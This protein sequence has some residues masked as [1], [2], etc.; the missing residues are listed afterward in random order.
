MDQTIAAGPADITLAGG[1]S[2]YGTMGQGGNV[3]EWMET[4]DDLANNSTHGG[5]FDLTG[6][7]IVDDADLTQWLSDAAAHNGFG[8]EYLAGDSDLDGSID[9][10]D[11]N[12]LALKWRQNVALWSGGDFTADG[13]VNAAHLNSLALEWR[14]AIPMASSANAPVPEPSAMLLSVLGLVLVWRRPRRS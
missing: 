9:A 10:I 13:M 14:Q 5:L 12:N 8:Q 7:G 3:Y 11:L 1:L 6:E 4:E 2:P